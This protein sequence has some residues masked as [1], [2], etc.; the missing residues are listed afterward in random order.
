MFSPDG[1]VCSHH[2]NKH[3]R[4]SQTLTKLYTTAAISLHHV[5]ASSDPQFELCG[6]MQCNPSEVISMSAPSGAEIQVEGWAVRGFILLVKLR[7]QAA[8]RSNLKSL[9]NIHECIIYL[10]T[11]LN[12]VVPCPPLP[13]LMRIFH[14]SIQLWLMRWNV[15]D[16]SV[17]AHAIRNKLNSN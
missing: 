12:K 11:A 6:K 8:Q 4:V 15:N 9:P 5:S 2:P 7:L 14:C 13:P 1:G 10:L 17:Y 16:M 3:V